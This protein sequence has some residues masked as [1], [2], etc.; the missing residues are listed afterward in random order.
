MWTKGDSGSERLGP[1]DDEE[2]RSFYCDVPDFLSTK[3]H[4]LLGI[5]EA[6]V[7]KQREKNKRQYGED[8][9]AEIVEMSG[10]VEETLPMVE[11]EGEDDENE[12]GEE[13]AMEE[14]KGENADEENNYPRKPKRIDE[15]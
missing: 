10:D 4:A 2:T 3:P 15:K 7:E 6:D 11:E 8:E 1:F 12:K 9:E 14:S 13:V 5:S